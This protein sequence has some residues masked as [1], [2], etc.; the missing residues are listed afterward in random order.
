MID[1]LANYDDF[2]ENF[3]KPLIEVCV[4]EPSTVYTKLYLIFDRLLRER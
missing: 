3:E 1:K 4:L 2:E